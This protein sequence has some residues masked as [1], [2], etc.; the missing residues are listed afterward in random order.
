MHGWDKNGMDLEKVG[1][2]IP[3]TSNLA[4]PIV[5][6][7]QKG[8]IHPQNFL[9]NGNGPERSVSNSSIGLTLLCK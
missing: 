5:I 8:P 2:L 6:V 1:I 9:Q 3:S 4:S 7:P